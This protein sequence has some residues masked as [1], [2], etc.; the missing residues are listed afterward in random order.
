MARQESGAQ[1]GVG[2]LTFGCGKGLGIVPLVGSLGAKLAVGFDAGG[3]NDHPPELVE[4]GAIEENGAT[5]G[6]AFLFV[7]QFNGASVKFGIQEV[8]GDE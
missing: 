8:G 6:L 3:I 2:L 4:L 7:M 1:W 5:Q